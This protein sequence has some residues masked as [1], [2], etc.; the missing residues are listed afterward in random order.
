MGTLFGHSL[1]DTRMQRLC[2]RSIKC[3]KNQIFS[4]VRQKVL[5]AQRPTGQAPY[6]LRA[7]DVNA[8]TLEIAAISRLSNGGYDE[9]TDIGE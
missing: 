4:T 8:E 3:L 7:F 6:L 5:T 1:S 2:C 9:H